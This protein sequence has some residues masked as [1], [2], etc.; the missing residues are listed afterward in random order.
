MTTGQPQSPTIF[1]LSDNEN[2]QIGSEATRPPIVYSS[3]IHFIKEY[4]KN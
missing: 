2:Q 1:Q 3:K 4:L